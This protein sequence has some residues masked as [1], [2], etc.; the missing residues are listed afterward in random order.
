MEESKFRQQEKNKALEQIKSGQIFNGDN[1]KKPY[2]W[3]GKWLPKADLLLDGKNNLYPQIR[4]EVV[5]YFALNKITFHHLEGDSDNGFCIPSGHTLS[6]QIS[7]LNH[8]YPLRYDKDA[9][10]TIAKMICPDFVDVLPIDT[11]E[12]FP[13]Y[14]Q[15]ESVSEIDHLNEVYPPQVKPSRGE[16]STS[17]DALIYAVH[18]DNEGKYL[19][20]IEWKY[21]EEYEYSKLPDDK[22]IGNSGKKRLTR[23]SQLIEDSKFLKS[24]PSYENSIYFFE[25]F[26]QLMRQTLWA[27]QMINNRNK[28]RIKAINFIHVHIIPN[29][30]KELL[31]INYQVTGKNME[32][33]WIDSLKDKGKYRIITPT[34]LLKGIDKNKYHDLIKYIESRYW[35]NT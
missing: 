23:Y 35:N 5:L 16:Y 21:T 25:P 27:E 14:I 11:D 28:E 6:S 20:P 32:E 18:K 34:D 8:L 1:G 22:S 26:Y 2:F 33:S 4:D 13:A 30:N 24:L 9:V 10:L 17:I 19:I 3:K 31:N 7:C 12:Y 29:E 15:F